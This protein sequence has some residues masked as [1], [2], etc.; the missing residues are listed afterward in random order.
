MHLERLRALCTE[1]YKTINK[2]N[3]NL[4]SMGDL[5]KLRLTIKKY[6]LKTIISDFKQVSDEK[7]SLSFIILNLLKI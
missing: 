2:L 6:I 5:S 4:R 7:K 3:P 1:L